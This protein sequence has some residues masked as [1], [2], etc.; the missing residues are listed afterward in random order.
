ML[1]TLG[2]GGGR[3]IRVG[4]VSRKQLDGTPID[5]ASKPNAKN[6]E[7]LPSM[8]QSDVEAGVSVSTEPQPAPQS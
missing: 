8:N 2:D 5:L 4:L 7:Y 1:V 3:K 6:E